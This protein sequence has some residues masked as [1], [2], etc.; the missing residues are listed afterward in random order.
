MSQI[1]L[2]CPLDGLPL[3]TINERGAVRPGDVD[4]DFVRDTTQHAHVIFPGGATICGNGH[5]WEW[6]SFDLQ[7]QRARS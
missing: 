2:T 7:L 3:R 1:S 4:G 6:E 5:A